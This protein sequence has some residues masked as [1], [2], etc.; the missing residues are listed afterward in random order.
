MRRTQIQMLAGWIS[1]LLLLSYTAIH[2]GGLLAR[3]INPWWL[4]Y[5]AAAGIEIAIV[6]L[7]LRIG[8]VRRSGQNPAFFVFVLVATVIVS[9]VANVAE[10]FQAAE[11][12]LIS[13]EGIAGL[14][15]IQAGIGLMATGLISIIVFA[16]S[17]I[18]G[19]DVRAAER[20]RIRRQRAAERK[21]ADAEAAGRP[22]DGAGFPYPIEA[23]REKLQQMRDLSRREAQERLLD[24]LRQDPGLPA[25]YLAQA[26]GRS[27]STMYEYLR[28]LERQGRI[29]RN[30]DG[31]E[32]IE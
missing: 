7:S 22:Q 31:I 10:G 29:R 3:Y 12:A 27:R 16:M 23:A 9:A 30:G 15:P 25:A 4:G 1:L 21:M 14:D 8:E 28:D 32:V 20:Q 2:T 6:S 24:L 26:I 18:V 13:L 5:A 11:G 19:S 17:E